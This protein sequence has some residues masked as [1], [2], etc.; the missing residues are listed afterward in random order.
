M[1]PSEK[2]TGIVLSGGK[3]VRMGMDK[4]LIEWNGKSFMKHVIDAMTPLVREMII[5][6]DDPGHQIEGIP[7]IPDIMPSAGPL[8]GICTGLEHSLSEFN[9]ILSCDIPLIDTET[10]R[11]LL[12]P[13]DTKTDMV[14]L[15]DGKRSMPLIA[16]YRKRC[17][18][19]ALD[20]LHSGKRRMMD[21]TE[22]LNCQTILVP[23]EDR[24]RIQNINSPIDLN[25]IN[26][27]N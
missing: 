13:I 3:S 19:P 17:L 18:Q 2:I 11:L 4:A 6:S 9:L 16:L 7:R 27:A 20:L 14:L 25:A 12:D 24:F 23:K 22:R 5:V 8:A 21:L 26:H 15:S 1:I 10:L